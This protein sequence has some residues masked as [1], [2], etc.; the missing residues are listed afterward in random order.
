MYKSV[1][2]LPYLGVD[3]INKDKNSPRSVLSTCH[4]PSHRNNPFHNIKVANRLPKLRPISPTYNSIPKSPRRATATVPLFSNG[5]S[6]R[7]LPKH[8]RITSPI[9]RP[10]ATPNFLNSIHE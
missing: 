5:I 2:S 1:R 10:V 3:S 4:S 7:I 9:L 8:K 6:L